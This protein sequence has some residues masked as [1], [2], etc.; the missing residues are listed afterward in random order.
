[1]ATA[2]MLSSK[3]DWECFS[4][5]FSH[6]KYFCITDITLPFL[7]W[8]TDFVAFVAIGGKHKATLHHC[9]SAK[10]NVTLNLLS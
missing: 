5:V 9:T 1:V 10:K 3:A 8:Q 6:S 7:N 2:K 4:V